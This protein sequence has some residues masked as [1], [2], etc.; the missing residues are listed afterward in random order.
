MSRARLL[1]CRCAVSPLTWL[2]RLSRRMDKSL[3]AVSLMK[4]PVCRFFV[5]AWWW[6]VVYTSNAQSIVD[7]SFL[8]ALLHQM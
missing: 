2:K 7:G 4:Y 3:V 8:C 6:Q 5:A 1:C